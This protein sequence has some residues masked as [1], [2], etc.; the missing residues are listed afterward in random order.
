MAETFFADRSKNSGAVDEVV[1]R[2]LVR[3]A[4][5]AGNFTHRNRIG[6]TGGRNSDGR[7]KH[8]SS[9]RLRSR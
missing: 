1:V 9:Q 8:R 7:I 3:N 4:S 2:G 6:A 5:L